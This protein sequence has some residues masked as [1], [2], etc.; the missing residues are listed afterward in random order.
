M[1]MLLATGCSNG[2]P[3]TPNVLIVHIESEA[4]F[5]YSKKKS[6]QLK[7]G[8]STLVATESTKSN[9]SKHSVTVFCIQPFPH[10]FLDRKHT[11]SLN[12][13]ILLIF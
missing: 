3:L 1:S 13:H 2:K 9:K 4:D 7:Q 5:C 11:S 12:C 6:K 10:Y 8:G